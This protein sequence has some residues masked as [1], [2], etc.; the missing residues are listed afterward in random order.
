[1]ASLLLL[2]GAQLPLTRTGVGSET[3]AVETLAVAGDVG[4][5]ALTWGA[6]LLVLVLAS[7]L[8]LAPLAVVRRPWAGAAWAAVA[9]LVVA[10]AATIGVV[11]RG[12]AGGA[13]WLVGV[14]AL[15]LAVG[16]AAHRRSG[17]RVAADSLRHTEET[18]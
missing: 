8:L 9:G 11:L 14:A 4:R 3:T 2:G 13:V 1:M 15:A 7:G 17:R 6:R 18:A 12:N 5:P 16:E 10:I